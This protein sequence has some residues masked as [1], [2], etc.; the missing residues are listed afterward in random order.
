VINPSGTKITSKNQLRLLFLPFLSMLLG[1]FT[2]NF[3][4]KKKDRLLLVR[5]AIGLGS[6][7]ILSLTKPELSIISISLLILSLFLALWYFYLH[8]SD[9]INFESLSIVTF[10]SMALGLVIG[11]QF[12]Q[13]Y[14]PNIYY[15]SLFYF[16]PYFTSYFYICRKIRKKEDKKEINWKASGANR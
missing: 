9:R 16:I 3:A 12:T 13:E 11:L 1:F 7:L 14:F 4:A 5:F 2:G 10:L 8:N 15:F 6:I